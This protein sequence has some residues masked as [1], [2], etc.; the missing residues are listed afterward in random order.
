MGEKW[1]EKNNTPTRQNKVRG[2]EAEAEAEKKDFLY[3]KTFQ[4]LLVYMK[5]WYF[6]M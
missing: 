2:A 6:D 5:Y 1:C 3:T 4:R